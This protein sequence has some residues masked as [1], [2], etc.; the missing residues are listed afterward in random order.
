MINLKR[1]CV[2]RYETLMTV[3]IFAVVRRQSHSDRSEAQ[4]SGINRQKSW[5]FVPGLIRGRVL[6]HAI[7]LG[8]AVGGAVLRTEF[9]FGAVSGRQ[10]QVCLDTL[11]LLCCISDGQTPLLL[12]GR[13]SGKCQR[14]SV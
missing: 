3:L 14:G 2:H 12:D 4:I 5:K 6:C 13:E 11:P 10:F 8:G 7:G 1:N 9:L